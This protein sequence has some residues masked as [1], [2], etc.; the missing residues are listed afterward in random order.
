MP[1]CH[2]PLLL[3]LIAPA[4]IAGPRRRQT[5]LSQR[6]CVHVF[7]ER[8]E[9]F[10]SLAGSRPPLPSVITSSSCYFFA[11]ATVFLAGRANLSGEDGDPQRSK[12]RLLQMRLRHPRHSTHYVIFTTASLASWSSPSITFRLHARVS[13]FWQFLPIEL[14]RLRCAPL[15][16]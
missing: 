6:W 5:L 7:A 8:E 15:K 12:T 11:A 1:F 13:L 3:C 9:H 14:V 4:Y 2:I 10:L 16:L